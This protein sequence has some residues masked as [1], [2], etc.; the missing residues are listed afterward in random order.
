MLVKHT[1]MQ[2]YFKIYSDKGSIVKSTKHIRQ[3]VIAGLLLQLGMGIACRSG[4][5]EEGQALS[6]AFG[7]NKE[8]EPK[9]DS[10][11]IVAAQKGNLKDL[12]VALN[13]SKVNIDEI[14]EKSGKTALMLACGNGHKRVVEILLSKGANPHV[15]AEW[16]HNSAVREAVKGGHVG[17]LKLL[18]RDKR[19]DDHF[20]LSLG[21]SLIE[22]AIKGRNDMVRL[23]LDGGA[24]P[25]V[26]GGVEAQGLVCT[27]AL[28][29][30]AANG[31]QDMVRL[32]LD[33]G[34]DINVTGGYTY[35]TALMEA[36][37]NGREAVMSLLLDKGADPNIRN[38]GGDTAL[39]WAKCERHRALI[40]SFIGKES[41]LMDAVVNGDS[42]AVKALIAAGA[43]VNARHKAGVTVLIEAAARGYA[44][45]VRA[46]ID[47]GANV[48]DRNVYGFTALIRAT[49]KGSTEIV[50]ALID[51]GAARDCD[52]LETAYKIASHYSGG[53]AEIAELLTAASSK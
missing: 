47:A 34:A 40:Q 37:A 19:E 39:D 2:L 36:A 46:L 35:A 44:D 15:L 27:Y 7:F 16:G 14:G 20:R 29:E 5:A 22:A 49:E 33:N 43:N 53:K 28:M 6:A 48:N 45:I 13:D 26:L 11:L 30:A 41:K 18:L 3:L 51:A 17:V 21:Y 12:K 42:K 38:T 25:N 24:N 32:L 10:K 52:S 4:F 9:K 1:I 23:L 8:S 50:R 31:H